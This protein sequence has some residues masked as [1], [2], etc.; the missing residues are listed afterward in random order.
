MST[1]YQGY[2]QCQQSIKDICQCQHGVKKYDHFR[3][4]VSLSNF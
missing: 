4:T 2:S 1:W 3:Q